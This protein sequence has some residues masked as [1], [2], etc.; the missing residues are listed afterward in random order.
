MEYIEFFLFSIISFSIPIFI[1]FL[2][3]RKKAIKVKTKNILESGIKPTE[4]TS[5]THQNKFY[6]IAIM[7]IFTL[8][9]MILLIPIAVLKGLGDVY[10]KQVMISICILCNALLGYLFFKFSGGFNV[11]G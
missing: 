5:N 4:R 1:A 2:K 7:M 3:Y 10:D 6:P 11:L 9:P 8:L